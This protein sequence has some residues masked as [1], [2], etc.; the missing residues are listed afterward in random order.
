MKEIIERG[1]LEIGFVKANDFYEIYEL[2]GDRK[3]WIKFNEVD[4]TIFLRDFTK[5]K[6]KKLSYNG[7]DHTLLFYDIMKF[8]NDYLR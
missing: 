5:N 1:I 6:Y 4:S 8:F 7:N 2:N 3:L